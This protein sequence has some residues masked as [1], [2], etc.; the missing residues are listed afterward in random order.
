MPSH[1]MGGI[2]VVPC[3]IPTIPLKLRI[4]YDIWKVEQQFIPNTWLLILS[5]ARGREGVRV[6]FIAENSN[7]KLDKKHD[8]EKYKT[9]KD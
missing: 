9:G 5:E 4:G 2:F 1:C 6:P 7:P 8:E 3:I